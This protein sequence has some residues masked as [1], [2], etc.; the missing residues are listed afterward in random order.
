WKH[1]KKTNNKKRLMAAL[2]INE[3]NVIQRPVIMQPFFK[4]HI[5]L[6]APYLLQNYLMLNA[7]LLPTSN[8]NL[9]GEFVHGFTKV[10]NRITLGKKLASQIFHPQIHTSLIEFLLQVEHTGSRRD[11]EQLFSINLPKSPMLRLLYPIVDHQD[12]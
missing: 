9:Y 8:G 5:F 3:Q 12:N 1:F 10:S 6:K 2:I 11:Y 7:V 4:Q